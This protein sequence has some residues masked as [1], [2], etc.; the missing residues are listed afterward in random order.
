MACKQISMMDYTIMSILHIN[1][2]NEAG[3]LESLKKGQVDLTISSQVDLK[4]LVLYKFDRLGRVYLKKIKN[5]V[6]QVN[7]EDGDS[8]CIFE[9]NPVISPISLNRSHLDQNAL[10]DS[11]LRE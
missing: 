11:W 3:I 10:V 4:N 9:K 7:V 6:F 8:I 5:H 2:A 1:G